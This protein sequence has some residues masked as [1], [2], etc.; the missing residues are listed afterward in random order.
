MHVGK[1]VN[2]HEGLLRVFAYFQEQIQQAQAMAD[3]ER[4]RSN[5]LAN[6]LLG[7]QMHQRHVSVARDTTEDRRHVQTPSPPQEV[8]A[9]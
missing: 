7:L 8:E 1:Q 9:C 3:Q 5:F 4:Q 6:E 2:E